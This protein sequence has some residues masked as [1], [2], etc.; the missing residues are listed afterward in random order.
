MHI[1]IIGGSGFLGRHLAHD[2]VT[3]GHKVTIKT[4]NKTSTQTLDNQAITLIE[5]FDEVGGAVSSTIFS[6]HTPEIGIAER[7][8]GC[9]PVFLS[10]RP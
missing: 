9:S 5:Q 2:L 4:R 10:S 7:A 8:D 3:K 6:I 1:L